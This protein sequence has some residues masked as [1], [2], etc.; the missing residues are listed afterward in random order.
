MNGNMKRR[1]IRNS[2]LINGSVLGRGFLACLLLH[3]MHAKHCC[4]SL[5]L[6]PVHPL[7]LA[8]L[9][10]E[11]FSIVSSYHEAKALVAMSRP[12][13][14]TDSEYIIK[15]IKILRSVSNR[16]KHIEHKYMS[17]ITAENATL[18]DESVNHVAS[19]RIFLAKLYVDTKENVLAI[20]E[21][22]EACPVAMDAQIAMKPFDSVV[23][24][25]F[26][27]FKVKHQSLI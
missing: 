17:T 8:P 4:Q 26:I 3:G 16:W 1:R 25:L 21:Y 22:E 20:A 23:L 5:K 13:G 24:L 10:E 2:R 15:A 19:T 7:P 12:I 11:A 9:S 18:F 14:N 6:N 27:D